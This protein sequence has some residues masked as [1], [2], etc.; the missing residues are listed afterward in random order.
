MNREIC[1]TIGK[2]FDIVSDLERNIFGQEFEFLRSVDDKF[3]LPMASFSE[4]GTVVNILLYDIANDY[5]D[6]SAAGT[7]GFFYFRRLQLKGI[8]V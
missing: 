4:T 7:F 8:K 2:T 5:V 3:D 6:G 1:E